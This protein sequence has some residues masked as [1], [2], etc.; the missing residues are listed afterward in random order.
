MK[1]L[2]KFLLAI[3]MV[4]AS[5]AGSKVKAQNQHSFEYSTRCLT[6]S[7]WAKDKRAFDSCA[8]VKFT[9]NG[10]YVSGVQTSYTFPKAGTYQVCMKIVNSCK[11]WDTIVCR[12]ITV[13]DCKC[14]MSKA[15]FGYSNKCMD[16]VFEGNNIGCYKYQFY[17]M[18]NST[19]SAVTLKAGRVAYH[20]FTSNGSYTVKAVIKDTCNNC[21]TTIYQTIKVD[22]N[23]CSLKPEFSWKSDCLKAKFIA[24]GNVSGAKYYWS[25]GDGYY[26]DK[27]E[28]YHNYLKTGT[29]KVCLKMTWKDPNTGKECSET[30]C[31]EVKISCGK[32]CNL[33]GEFKFSTNGNFAKFSAY[34]NNGYY[35][36][37]SFGDGTTGSGQNPNHYYKKAGTYEVCVTIYDKTKKCHIKICKKVVIQD[38]CNVRAYFT[39]KQN[40]STI[41]FLGIAYNGG[42]YMWDFGDGNYGYG[43]DPKHTYSKAGTYKV[44]LTVYSLNGKC[45]TTVCKTI[46]IGSTGSKC[47]WKKLGADFSYSLNCPKLVIEGKNLNN[48]GAMCISYQFKVTDSKGNSSGLLNGR[49]QYLTLSDGVYNVCMKLYDSCHKCDTVICKTITVKC[50]QSKCDWSR[51]GLNYT[52]NCNKITMEA[53]NMNSGS[54]GNGCFKYK[55][56]TGDGNYIYDRTGSYTYPKNG[57]YTICVKITDTCNNC[58]TTICKYVTVNCGSKCDLSK[59]GFSHTLDCNKLTVQINNMNYGSNGNGCYK[60]II[61]TGD[62]NYFYNRTASYTYPKNGTYT[63]CIK[64]MDTCNN[65]DTVICKSITVNCNSG[66]K[67]NWKGAGFSYKVDCNKVTF[68]GIDLNNKCVA[69][70]FA[71]GSNLLGYGRTVSTTFTAKGS[72]TVCLKLYDTCNKCDTSICQTIKID[73]LP[74]KAQAKFSFDSSNTSGVAYFTNLSTGGFYYKWDFGDTTYDYNKNPGKHAYKYS[75]TY[76][77]CLT[78]WDSAKTCSTKYCVQ[79]KVVKNRA[80]VASVAPLPLIKLY[81]NPADAR[82]V[83]STSGMNGTFEVMSLQGKVMTTGIINGETSVSTS[84]WSEGVYLVKTTFASGQV[85]ERIVI[86]RQ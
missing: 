48:S 56:F 30:I 6:V 41:N 62:G 77:V 75:G 3:V 81:P 70:V 12:S 16:Y 45:K 19:N 74:C 1:N 55:L 7:L 26:S 65:C 34:S 38:P 46:T 72:Y 9:L 78:V 39:F 71:M 86:S 23:P 14:D 25:F 50:G 44:C 27:Q 64:V 31:K 53:N 22:C 29:Y 84:G 63:L 52:L 49:I 8:Q 57:T 37:W 59:A 54:S 20:T 83:I 58:D 67:C 18:N 47:N 76:Y 2:Y 28:A 42:K 51:A 85:T 11:K 82:F 66:S 32:E 4:A 13:A 24:G 5:A 69:Y 80:S 61:A 36:H 73:C 33:K 35:Y 43:R 79:I 60:Y 68:E 40:G 17:V 15:G 10:T 21:D